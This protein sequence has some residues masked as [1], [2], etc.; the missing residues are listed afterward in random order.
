M[1]RSG[2][3]APNARRA[4]LGRSGPLRLARPC[5]LLG[6]RGWQH[7]GAGSIVA[8]SEPGRDVPI[9]GPC[10]A[11]SSL[12]LVLI[13][14]GVTLSHWENRSHASVG[15]TVSTRSPA[16]ETSSNPGGD[17]AAPIAPVPQTNDGCGWAVPASLSPPSP[18]A[19][20][21]SARCRGGGCRR[22]WSRA[23]RQQVPTGMHYAYLSACG[24]RDGTPW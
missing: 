14:L 8:W 20:R 21:G 7:H 17:A 1:S 18:S 4:L 12:G 9:S 23:A 3:G 19:A 10:L 13:L 6:W 15:M 24:C 22:L 11:G 5:R 16:R 2:G